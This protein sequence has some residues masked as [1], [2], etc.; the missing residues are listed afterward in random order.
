MNLQD[1]LVMQEQELYIN[2]ISKGEIEGMAQE[3]KGNVVP[4]RSNRVG[5]YP[6]VE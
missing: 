1:K 4:L 5:G 6:L 2:E 3:D